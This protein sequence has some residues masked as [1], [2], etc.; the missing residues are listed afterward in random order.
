MAQSEKII[1]IVV[2]V[3]GN[4]IGGRNYFHN[5]IK[6]LYASKNIK[7]LIYVFCYEDTFKYFSDKFNNKNIIVVNLGRNSKKNKVLRLVSSFLFGK[8]FLIARTV[9]KYSCDLLIGGCEPYGKLD[10]DIISWIPDFQHLDLKENF[11]L[12]Q[13]LYRNLIFFQ[14]LRFSKSIIL[15]SQHAYSKF[16]NNYSTNW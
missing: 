9:K 4:W 14:Q 11:T 7:K 1:G 6:I 15:S 5:F 12:G 16:K 2:S 3:T 10:C 13:R 8:D